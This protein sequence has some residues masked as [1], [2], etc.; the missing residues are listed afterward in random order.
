MIIKVDSREKK[1]W[2]W[3]QLWHIGFIAD[4]NDKEK[5]K[6]SL[7]K[8][9]LELGDFILCDDENKE[10]IIIERKTLSDLGSSIKDGRY[11]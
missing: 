8:K 2:K 3:L 9:T 4:S 7:E 1:L 6:I 11:K 5:E 10:I